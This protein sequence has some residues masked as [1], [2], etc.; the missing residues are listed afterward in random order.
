MVQE[1]GAKCHR[2]ANVLNEVLKLDCLMKSLCCNCFL[3]PKGPDVA[4][5]IS[6]YLSTTFEHRA[7]HLLADKFQILYDWYD[8]VDRCCPS[9]TFKKSTPDLLKLV[10]FLDS[11]KA[12]QAIALSAST[13]ELWL[14]D[15]LKHQGFRCKDFLFENFH[16]VFLLSSSK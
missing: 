14:T 1:L 13:T 4:Q 15:C 11:K 9:F 8:N 12:N 6:Q 16:G 2:K 7:I 3:H 10:V 5:R